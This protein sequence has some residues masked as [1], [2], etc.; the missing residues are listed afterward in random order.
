M[1][2]MMKLKRTEPLDHIESSDQDAVAIAPAAEE[3]CPAPDARPARDPSLRTEPRFTAP[4]LTTS[5]FTASDFTAERLVPQADAKRLVSRTDTEHLTPRADTERL[6][7]RSDTLFP[8]TEFPAAANDLGPVE[9]Q[10]SIRLDREPSA[11][12]RAMKRALTGFII[13]VGGA[14]ATVQAGRTSAMM[15][16]NSPKGWRRTCR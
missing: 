6:A 8:S 1:L 12:G 9:N 3:S 4:N 15:P 5:D 10:P 2:S 11:F 14:V 16:S 13:I 7:P